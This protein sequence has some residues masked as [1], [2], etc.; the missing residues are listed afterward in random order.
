MASS[1][2][3]GSAI[4]FWI[5]TRD[6]TSMHVFPPA[7]PLEKIVN[8]L[9]DVQPTTLTSYPSMLGLLAG[10]AAAGRLRIRP[11]SVGCGGEPL[12]PEVRQAAESAFGVDVVNG[13]GISEVGAVASSNPPLRGLHL[14]EHIGV[15]EPVDGDLQP[16]PPGVRAASLLVTNVLNDTL[17]IIRYQITDEVT[18]LAEPNPGPWPG[19]RIADIEGRID[20][21]FTYPHGPVVHPHVIRSILAQVPA[22]VEYQVRQTGTGIDI[23]LRTN[24]EVDHPALSSKLTT[25]LR[26]LGLQNAHVTIAVVDRIERHQQSG[27]L[28]RFVPLGP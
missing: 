16:V 9:N 5:T 6:L 8:G 7:L 19:R 28:K 27:K 20:E 25:A 14:N 24:G 17:P 1:P 10:E 12:L 21:V 3:H 4:I 11:D 22:V 2:L 26:Q 13:Y 15:Y 23:S 18:F